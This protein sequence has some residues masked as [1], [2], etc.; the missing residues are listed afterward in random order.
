[1]AKW[2]GIV[3]WSVLL[4]LCCGV[5]A[6]GQ[7]D[8][9]DQTIDEY[10]SAFSMGPVIQT[11]MWSLAY[12]PI[13][14]GGLVIPLHYMQRF[15]GFEPELL[16]LIAVLWLGGMVANYTGYAVIQRYG[17]A[18]T[19]GGHWLAVLIAAVIIFGWCVLMCS[20][21]WADLTVKEALLV[22]GIITVLCAPYFG[23]TWHIGR[24][25]P[26]NE[27]ARMSQ[28]AGAQAA[29]PGLSDR[30]RVVPVS[31]SL[32]GEYAAEYRR[33]SALRL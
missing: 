29:C 8:D 5:A 6:F 31:M 21:P 14:A 23:P 18:N 2:S 22:G 13:F 33:R 9:L 30:L 20:L 11:L 4:V 15:A 1:M 10:T 26:V 32:A 28:H 19:A 25:K 3:F 12:L 16:S 7:A 27:E 17:D 24:T